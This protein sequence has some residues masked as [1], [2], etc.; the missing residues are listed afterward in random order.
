VIE[1]ARGQGIS[2]FDTHGLSEVVVLRASRT[3]ALPELERAVTEAVHGFDRRNVRD[4][5]REHR[6]VQKEDGR[7]GASGADGR[8]VEADACHV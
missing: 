6:P 2:V 3:I 8:G 1:A 5:A 4:P 7:D